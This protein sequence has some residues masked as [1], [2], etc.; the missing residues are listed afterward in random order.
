[1]P[2]L[3]TVGI[4]TNFIDVVEQ[5]SLSV[6]ER[7]IQKAERFLKQSKPEQVLDVMT[8]LFDKGIEL[9]ETANE[10]TLEFCSKAL[11]SLERGMSYEEWLRRLKRYGRAPTQLGENLK[12]S[13]KA[14]FKTSAVTP[15]LCTS[16]LRIC[17]Q[18]R[19]P[20]IPWNNPVM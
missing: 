1:M 9:S 12:E 7:Y 14:V 16:V 10:I 11:D 8:K 13:L 17:R 4:G 20:G 5:D 19:A 2:D 3:M 15:S 6:V 18:V